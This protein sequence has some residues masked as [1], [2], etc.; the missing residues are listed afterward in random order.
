MTCAFSIMITLFTCYVKRQCDIRETGMAAFADALSKTTTLLE[1]RLKHQ[2][3]PNIPTPTI[4]A[5]VEAIE[6]NGVTTMYV[7][8]CAV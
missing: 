7:N 3:K 1:L 6:K 4:H 8:R 5:F 2:F